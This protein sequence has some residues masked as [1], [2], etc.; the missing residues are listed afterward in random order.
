MRGHVIGLLVFS[1]IAWLAAIPAAGAGND[2]AREN[3]AGEAGEARAVDFGREIQ[4]LLARRC[5]ACHGPDKNE[6]G[7]R[8][9]RRETA[10]GEIDSGNRA[11]VPGKP[12]ASA[13]IERI[14]ETDESLRMPPEG[15]PLSPKEI[16]LF[17]RWIAAGAEWEQHWAFVPAKRQAIPAVQNTKWVRNAVD[18]FILA[19][20]EAAGLEPAPPA[21][22]PALLRRVYFDLVGLPPALDEVEAFVADESPNAYEQVVDRLLAS[23]HYGEKW[24]RHWLDLVRYAETNSYERDGLKPN[25]WRYRDYVIRSFNADKPYDRFILEQLAGDELPDADRGTIIATGYY[26]LG[27]WDDEPVDPVQAYYDE[28]DDIVRT[29]GEVFLG[30]T[31]GCARCHDHKI[32]PIPQSDYYRM[33]AFFH[34]LDTY[35]VR[36]DQLSNNQTDISPPELAAAHQELARKKGALREQMLT[37]EQ[38]AIVKMPAPDQRKTEGPEREQVLAA[39]LH[40]YLSAEQSEQYRTLKQS[41]EELERV[42]LPPREMALSVNKNRVPPPPTHVLLR[43]NA[44]AHGDRVEPG[45]PTL[46]SMPDPQIPPAPEGAGAAGRRIVLARWIASPEN[47]LTAR[48]LANRLWQF[49]F[50]RGLV[51]SSNNF[52]QLGDRPTHPALLDWLASELADVP[53]SPR[54]ATRGL[55]WSLKRM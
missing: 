44:H 6:G 37:I 23:P 35:G 24:G 31:I 47:M 25:A 39:T 8:L 20:L 53:G 40:E 42:K 55:G 27:L 12:D 38:A 15:E 17:R 49:H 48:V 22:K 2:A 43:G 3:S 10:L 4:P 26:R 13:L 33:L 34:D 18:A 32:D 9:N 16:E 46:F 21:D 29:T 36:S 51:R 11:V 52:G 30:L 19:R 1:I 50:G 14:R 54:V 7:L 28:M 45:Y 41:F 5:F